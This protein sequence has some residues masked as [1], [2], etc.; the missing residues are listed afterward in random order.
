MHDERAPR[1]FRELV[2]VLVRAIPRGRVMTY[3]QVARCLG[4]AR[5]AQAV[6]NV[7]YHTPAEAGVPCQRVVNRYGGLAAAYGW[8]GYARH[9]ADLEADGVEVREDH[10]VDLEALRWHPPHELVEDLAIEYGRRLHE[11]EGTD[12]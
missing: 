1:P 11:R 6:G 3:G 12:K 8:G 4:M 7:M 10:T 9:R 2:W 5:G